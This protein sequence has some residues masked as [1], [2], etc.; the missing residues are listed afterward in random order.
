M[1]AFGTS[2]LTLVFPKLLFLDSIRYEHLV[3]NSLGEA[4]PRIYVLEIDEETLNAVPNLLT[5]RKYFES[6]I[7]KINLGK[8]GVIGFDIFFEANREAATDSTFA[9]R[10]SNDGK[11]ILGQRVGD[12]G[13]PIPLFS[14]LER[15][16]P[17]TG[18]ISLPND[19]FDQFGNVLTFPTHLGGTSESITPSFPIAILCS[20]HHVGGRAQACLDWYFDNEIPQC[21]HP[22]FSEGP[23]CEI[24]V[25]YVGDLTSFHR[26]KL[27]K[28]VSH[29]GKIDL[30]NAIVLI[31][32]TGETFGDYVNVPV[33][34]AA[35]GKMLGVVVHA[36]AINTV[37]KRNWIRLL[38]ENYSICV[39]LALSLL[40]SAAHFSSRPGPVL[41]AIL[42]VSVVSM[43]LIGRKF[44]TFLPMTAALVSAL[45]AYYCGSAFK[46]RLR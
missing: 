12:D 31:G 32:V 23:A 16:R 29:P 44:Q 17:R 25:R 40:A 22:I 21:A 14:T 39:P 41:T 2:F 43:E 5:D 45:T 6:A 13:E 26:M 36:N 8:N 34:T 19:R 1:I 10:A 27:E 7:A 42:I 9:R 4:D 33:K 28:V 24:A 46:K 37:I 18:L 3:G 11:I 38:D 30:E 20:M 35:G 15:N